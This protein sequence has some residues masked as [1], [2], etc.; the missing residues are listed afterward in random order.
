MLTRTFFVQLGIGL[1]A[2]AFG[3]HLFTQPDRDGL[4]L[5]FALCALV[6]GAG[7]VVSAVLLLRK[8][9]RGSNGGDGGRSRP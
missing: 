2:V 9:R 4:D 3:M 5:F 6:G 1:L 8:K 7:F